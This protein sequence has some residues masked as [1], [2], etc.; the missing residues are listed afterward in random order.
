M[1]SSANKEL[2]MIT[3]SPALQLLDLIQSHRVTVVIYVAAKLGIAEL[4]RDGPQ[5]A[6]QL[7]DATGAHRPSLERLLRAFLA[8]GLCTY[9]DEDG[10]SLTQTGAALD[11]AASHS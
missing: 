4:L 5:S 1:H 11:G 6:S 10:Y 8:L 9:S 7:A 2:R 3:A